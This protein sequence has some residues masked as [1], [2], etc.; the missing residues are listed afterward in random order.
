[1]VLRRGSSFAFEKPAR[2][3][4]YTPFDLETKHK[5]K[6]LLDTFAFRLGDLFG[7]LFQQLLVGQHASAMAAA[8]ATIAL[9][10][11]WAVLGV[12]LG[13][14]PRAAAVHAPA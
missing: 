10:S 3:V 12:L 11:L 1:M 8:S 5:V 6:F 14:R 2:E 7:A 13:R 9:A 4:L